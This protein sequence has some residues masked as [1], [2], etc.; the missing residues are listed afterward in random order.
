M[1]SMQKELEFINSIS[2]LEQELES[3]DLKQNELELND[4]E[5]N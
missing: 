3:K 5:L 2:E 1:W 4:F